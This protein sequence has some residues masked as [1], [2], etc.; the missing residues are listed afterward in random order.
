MACNGLFATLALFLF[1]S[2]AEIIQTNGNQPGNGLD[3]MLR[4]EFVMPGH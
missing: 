2:F 1:F 3:G 4:L